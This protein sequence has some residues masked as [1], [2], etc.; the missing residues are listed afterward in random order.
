MPGKTRGEE[1]QKVRLTISWHEG[2]RE[3]ND[4]ARVA[5][6]TRGN[7]QRRGE[8][9]IYVIRLWS[10]VLHGEL[11]ASAF[12]EMF[13]VTAPTAPTAAPQPPAAAREVYAPPPA[14]PETPQQEQRRANREKNRAAAADQW[15][16]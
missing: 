13:G 5:E 7:P 1:P 3:L 2:A 9:G 16:N 11:S 12:W 6:L 14:M 8:A 10:Q 15:A 4:L